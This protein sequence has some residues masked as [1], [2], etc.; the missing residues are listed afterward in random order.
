M[1]VAWRVSQRQ[2]WPT[3][4]SGEGSRQN[5]G[6]WN[7]IGASVVYLSDTFALAQFEVLVNVSRERLTKL[8]LG[9]ARVEFSEHLVADAAQAGLPHDWRQSSWS[10]TTQ[11]LGD[12]WVRN[13]ASPILRVPSSVSPVDFNYLLNP[14]HRDFHTLVESRQIDIGPFQPFAFD[15]R[16]EGTL[17]PNAFIAWLREEKTIDIP[18]LHREFNESTGRR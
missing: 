6:R 14:L 3:A 13:G 9:A 4:F 10:T 16:L 12:E 8:D 11:K 5:G 15:S 1:I 18:S 7:S 17:L 2:F